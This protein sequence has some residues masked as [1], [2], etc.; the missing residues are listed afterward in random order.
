MIEVF[1]A[2]RP[3]VG[4]DICGDAIAVMPRPAGVLVAVADG[5]GHGPQAHEAAV[6]FCSYAEAHRNV[7]L[8]AIIVA[9]TLHASFTL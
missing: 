9:P 3:I 2:Q 5:L 4:G 1:S 6:T 7:P 8:E